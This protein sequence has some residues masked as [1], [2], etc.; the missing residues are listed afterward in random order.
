M[1][2][3]R[4]QTGGWHQTSP[5]SLR[6]ATLNSGAVWKTRWT[7]WAPPSLILIVRTVSVDVKQHWRRWAWNINYLSIQPLLFFFLSFLYRYL[8][9]MIPRV[10]AALCCLVGD[11]TR[12]RSSGLNTEH[13]KLG[14]TSGGDKPKMA[15]VPTTQIFQPIRQLLSELLGIVG[16]LFRNTS[17]VRQK[18]HYFWLQTLKRTASWNQA[19][20]AVRWL[21]HS[22][23]Q[24]YL[25]VT[26]GTA[27]YSIWFFSGKNGCLTTTLRPLL[28]MLVTAT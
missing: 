3:L 16:G 23:L 5:A 8:V 27:E 21:E 6:K 12:S 19:C 25:V 20:K 9:A 7:S 17:E 2:A 18:H 14:K 26:K 24:A 22:M 28:W 1:T 4:F 11:W 10:K 15:A 13:D